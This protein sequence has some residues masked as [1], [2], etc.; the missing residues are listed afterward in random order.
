MSSMNSPRLA[1]R[2]RAL[3]RRGGGPAAQVAAGQEFQP[4]FVSK[5][6]RKLMAAGNDT[7]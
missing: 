6:G 7:A 5:A 2:A 3:S 4:F 1:L